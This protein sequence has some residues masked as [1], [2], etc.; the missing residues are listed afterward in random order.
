M[1]S[2]AVGLEIGLF[3]QAL[4]PVADERLLAS[5]RAYSEIGRPLTCNW[6]IR[7]G[8]ITS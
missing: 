2:G 5:S 7:S 8:M 1:R 3:A 4:D 6:L